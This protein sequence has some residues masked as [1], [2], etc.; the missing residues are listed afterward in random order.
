LEDRGERSEGSC[1]PNR[2]LLISLP[3]ALLLLSL[4][5]S[6]GGGW[7]TEVRGQKVPALQARAIDHSAI[8]PL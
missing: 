4:G 1:F 7:R 3:P 5:R 8:S 6:E 2:D